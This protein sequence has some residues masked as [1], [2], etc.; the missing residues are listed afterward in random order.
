MFLSAQASA[1]ERAPGPVTVTSDEAY[2]EGKVAAEPE[3]AVGYARPGT[4][5]SFDASL[6]YYYEQEERRKRAGLILA[7]AVAPTLLVGTA[8]AVPALVHKGDSETCEGGDFLC[9]AGFGYYLMAG[10]VGI[11]G[12]SLAITLLIVGIAKATRGSR[13]IAEMDKAREIWN[14]K[15]QDKS[16]PTVSMGINVGPHGAGGLSLSVAF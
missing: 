11:V 15:P 13:R 7:A 9:F 3:A 8:I 2:L 5:R 4:G 12:P 14:H 6:G 10:F 1:Q 16:A